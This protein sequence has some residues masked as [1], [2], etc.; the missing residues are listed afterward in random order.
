LPNKE[1]IDDVWNCVNR[2]DAYITSSNFKTALILT[3]NVALFGAS[4]QSGFISGPNALVEYLLISAYLIFAFLGL[5][6]S[7]LAVSPNIKGGSGGPFYFIGLLKDS[8]AERQRN[9]LLNSGDVEIFNSLYRQYVD[10]S[11][12]ADKKFTYH[13]WSVRFVQISMFV[14]FILIAFH[15]FGSTA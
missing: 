14:L 9:F 8:E 11:R 2:V 15:I 1:R 5:F 10:I 12:V 4:Y 13:S 3:F 7:L 6:F